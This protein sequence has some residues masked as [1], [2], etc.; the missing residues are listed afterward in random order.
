MGNIDQTIFLCNI[1]P[2]WSTQHCIGNFPHKSCLLAMDQHCTGNF[3]MQC[4]PRYIQTKLQIIFLCKVLCQV[5]A[6]ISKLISSCNV[7]SGRSRQHCIAY[8][9]A[10]TC[11]CDLGQ[12][13]SSKFFVQ[14]CLRRILTK[15][16]RQYFYAMLSDHGQCNIA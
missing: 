11:L 9:P 4:W 12:H 13:C 8:F 2:A 10:K 15:L 1:A 5:W 6:K 7:G 14:Y 3:I 16:T